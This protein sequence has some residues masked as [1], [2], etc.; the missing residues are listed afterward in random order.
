[1]LLLLLALAQAREIAGVTLPDTASVGGQTL[2]L[3]GVGLR[4]KYYIDVY[5]GA[6]YLPSKTRSGSEAIS[7]DVPK[8]ITMHFIYKQVT[9]DQL[10]ETFSEGFAK[11][12][13]PAGTP[14]QLYGMLSDVKAGD[15]IVLDYA[16]GSGT[17]VTVRG[18]ARGTIPGTQFMTA[19]WTVFLGA[20]PPTA[21]L[22]AGMLGG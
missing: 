21:A 2:Q 12:A 6:L 15:E 1:M 22:K 20:S 3:N 19:L 17:T 18:K 13:P 11:A 7:K 9:K 4:E 10:V 8:R 14:D 5:V 16:P